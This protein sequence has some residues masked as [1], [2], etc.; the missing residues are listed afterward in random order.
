MYLTVFNNKMEVINET[1]LDKQKYNYRNCWG[2]VSKGFFIGIDN[3]YYKGIN[4]EQL[5]IDILQ[6]Q[7]RSDK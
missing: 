3:E 2:I 6:V 5:Q 4:Y 1:K 7:K